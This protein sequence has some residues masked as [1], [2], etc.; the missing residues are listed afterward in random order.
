MNGVGTW[1]YGKSNLF[2]YTD[3]CPY[4]NR[5][6]T[7][8][9]YDTREWFVIVFIPIIPLGKKRIIDSCPICTKHKSLP[10]KKYL[11]LKEKA[12]AE[13]DQKFQQNP[14]DP[15][16]AAELLQVFAA[17]QDMNFF[18]ETAPQILRLFPNN[19]KLLSTIGAIYLQ[20]GRIEQSRNYLEQSLTLHDDDEIRHMLGFVYTRLGDPDKAAECFGFILQKQ[21]RDKAASLFSLVDL[22]QVH[23]RHRDALTCMEQIIQLNPELKQNKGYLKARKLSEKNL[24]SGKPIKNKQM[25]SPQALKAPLNGKKAWA[26]AAMVCLA[27]FLVYLSISVY[28]GQR[29]KVYVVNGLNRPYEV[30][31]NNRTYTLPTAAYQKI[32]IPEGRIDLKV[33]DESLQIPLSMVE[34][35]SPFWKRALLERIYVIN[36]DTIA[37]IE[38]NK[39]YYHE[40]VNLAPAPEWQMH[41]G[42]PLYVFDGVHFPFRMF[43]EEIKMSHSGS[44]ARVQVKLFDT[45]EISPDR[46]PEVIE[47][48]LGFESKIDY[49]KKSLYYEPQTTSYLE[50]LFSNAD[51][52]TF[53]ETIRPGLDRV[54]PLVEWHRLYQQAIEVNDPEYDLAAEYK[55]RLEKTPDNADLQYLYGRILHQDGPAKLW[56][57]RAI[58]NPKPSAYAYFALAYDA[59]A[60]ADYPT[61]LNY[62]EKAL[63]L[64]PDN[65]NFCFYFKETLIA[66]SRLDQAAEFCKKHASDAADYPWMQDYVSLL[67]QLGKGDEA[68]QF[69]EQWCARHKE[70]YSEQDLNYLRKEDQLSA[71][72]TAGDWAAIEKII[73]EPNEISDKVLLALQSQKTISDDLLA[74]ADSFPPMWLLL[75]YISESQLGNEKNAAL[76]LDEAAK[77]FE[78]GDFNERFVSRCLKDEKIEMDN[79]CC[80][81]LDI[82]LKPVVLTALGIRFPEYREKFFELAHQLNYKKVFPYHFLNSVHKEY[83]KKAAAVAVGQQI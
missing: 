27:A 60:V 48:V 20:Y 46:L 55:A 57:E 66:S 83:G 50:N 19:H 22:Y 81:S 61:A 7:L 36:P 21:V 14:N 30:V 59:M 18:D 73:G 16:A 23:G 78:R 42:K 65:P 69:F 67:R 64:N 29:A 2:S 54:P 5:Y 9:S 37:L 53:I 8:S 45:S 63:K 33:T 28:M 51:A 12:Y 38:W 26:I 39:V 75:C 31:L 6:V 35:H 79:V 17:Y 62:C 4:C 41:Y 13:A 52:D 72:Y 10:L 44:E 58:Q 1:Y 77:R 80:I 43:P 32:A 82:S 3:F 34:M 47:Q 25:G 24:A 74:Q 56:F 40:N 68:S 70:I 11:Q 76:F 71:A 49:L 15:E